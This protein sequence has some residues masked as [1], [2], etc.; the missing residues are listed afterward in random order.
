[1]T[2]SDCTGILHLAGRKPTSRSISIVMDLFVG[3]FLLAVFVASCVDLAGTGHSISS[4]QTVLGT[5]GAA[6]MM[7]NM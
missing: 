2:F 4:D 5:L 6:P 7:L 1:M 3:C